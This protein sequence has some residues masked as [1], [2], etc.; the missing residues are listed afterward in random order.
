MK[1]VFLAI[2]CVLIIATIGTA[3]VNKQ[4]S[5][6][7]PVIYW[8]T[9]NNP[10]RAL[11]ISTFQSWMKK[12][13]YPDCELR[14]D[15]A[16]RDVSKQIIQSVSGVGGDVMDCGSS[17]GDVMYFAE[18]GVMEDVTEDAKKL[19]FDPSKTYP[20]LEDDLK[21]GDKQYIFPCNVSAGLYFVNCAIFKKLGLEPPPMRWDIAEFERRGREFSEVANKGLERREYF[22]AS[23]VDTIP[24][25]RSFGNDV[26][27]ETLT[28]SKMTG[29][30]HD[31]YARAL[32]LNKKW[33][34]VDHILPSAAEV[35]SF[36]TDSGYGGVGFQLFFKGNFAMIST[37]RFA[38]IQFRQFGKMDLDAVEYPNGGYS[39][40]TIATRAA[41]V[42]KGGERKDLAKYFLAYLASEDYNMNIVNDADALPPNPEYTKCEEYLHPKD[43]PNE[44]EVHKK[45]AQDA[46]DISIVFTKS[47]FVANNRVYSYMSDSGQAVFSG[48]LTP[49]EAVKLCETRINEE[50]DRTLLEKPKL[51][52]EYD[53]Q[54]ELQKKIEEYRKAGRKIPRVW[55]SNPFHK[56]YYKDMGWLE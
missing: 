49:E 2:F 37:G 55:I 53:R 5:S 24:L 23:G 50:I 13:G 54:V 45:F 7:K 25:M 16:N 20:S 1:Y 26:F 28:G 11:Q 33:I 51:K 18:M 12:K 3:M 34:D 35:A 32:A 38:L 43:Y 48:K 8:V 14:L 41:L 52:P 29:E 4:T 6:G 40:T 10:A 15:T 42:Y 31:G 30:G 46:V 36:A 56:K 9:D 21:V 39:N 19:G 44:W 17:G 47:P 27:N 22:I